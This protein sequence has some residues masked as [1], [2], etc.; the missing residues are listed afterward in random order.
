MS[1]CYRFFL[2]N[3]TPKDLLLKTLMSTL[4]ILSFRNKSNLNSASSNGVLN[5]CK[6]LFSIRE[7]FGLEK[8]AQNNEFYKFGHFKY[9]EIR[10]GF[11]AIVTY[12]FFIGSLVGIFTHTKRKNNKGS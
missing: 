9:L 11:A 8:S 10:R 4:H 3:Y 5:D 7:L 12:Y 1:S 6:L 2:R